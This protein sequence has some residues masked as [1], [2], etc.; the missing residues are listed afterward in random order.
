M[1]HFLFFVWVGRGVGGQSRKTK[2]KT[3]TQNAAHERAPAPNGVPSPAH[4]HAGAARLLRQRALVSACEETK[5]RGQAF[6]AAACSAQCVRHTRLTHP[7]SPHSAFHAPTPPT[8]TP[9]LAAAIVDASLR[10][11]VG[12]V[13]APRLGVTVVRVDAARAA[14][15]V[16]VRARDAHTLRAALALA[17][18]V[19]GGGGGVGL[20]VGG[21][22]RCLLAL[23]A[24]GAA[25]DA[26]A[27]T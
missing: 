8:L 16:R 24:D 13:G 1:T 9:A 4:H 12:P 3:K 18:S 6:E 15:V 17:T 19:P 10:Q 20:S 26:A 7:L 5:E 22:A 2:P 25:F 21:S 11:L 27:V 23:A 14:A